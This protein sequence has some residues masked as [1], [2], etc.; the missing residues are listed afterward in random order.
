M[1][2]LLFSHF[3]QRAARYFKH[4]R[5]AK[6]TT[7]FLFLCIIGLLAAG[8]FSFFLHG[9]R[10]LAAT[11]YFKDAIL[12]YLYELFMFA[13][14]ILI[15][16]SAL[17]TGLFNLFYGKD[18]ILLA[19][20]PKFGIIPLLIFSRMFIASLWP[21]LI[22]VL[23]ALFAIG[24]VY[25]LS[26]V[27]S[28]LT[29]CALAVFVAFIVVS[30][31]T[32]IFFVAWLL[33]LINKSFLRFR[34]LIVG[35]LA[36]SYLLLFAAWHSTSAIHLNTLFSAAATQ[37]VTSDISPIR[38][39]FAFLPSHP[40]ALLLF[41]AGNDNLQQLLW[42]TALLITMFLIVFVP[43]FALKKR[44]LEFWQIFQES[45]SLKKSQRKYFSGVIEKSTSPLNTI[46][47]KEIVIFFRN[48]RGMMWFFFLSLMWLMQSAS[49]FI[50]NHQLSE[51]PQVTPFFVAALQIAAAIYFVNMF[52]LRFVYPSFSTEQKIGWMFRSAPIDAGKIFL[53]RVVFYVPFLSLLGL[54]FAL[55]NTF[56]ART[57]FLENMLVLG[58]IVIA[59]ATVTLYGLMLGAL[60]P[61][62]ETDDPEVL[63][64]SLPGLTFIFTSVI[65]GGCAAYAVQRYLQDTQ[66]ILLVCLILF[67]FVCS[68]LCIVLPYKK[69][70]TLKVQP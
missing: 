13:M 4:N 12:L 51:R 26:L 7:A 18:K 28:F 21:L 23:P 27:G 41:E 2:S 55:L 48:G 61:N 30:A 36:V 34:N 56:S 3:L 35:T 6:L 65:Y 47:R 52:V 15:F 16:A 31:M 17:I 37:A 62:Y 64:T 46:F 53:A 43:L 29:L 60:F 9:F 49:T 22:I 5:A 69:I 57:S 24:K 20:S 54:L 39:N 45:N 70:T 1:F 66:G 40:A 14:F 33:F 63:S 50:L 19:I 11:N 25:S 10:F 38:D 32:L 59:S 58:I 8:V 42:N 68:A 44:H 67:S